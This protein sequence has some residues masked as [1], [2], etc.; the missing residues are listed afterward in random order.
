MICR[1]RVSIAELRIVDEFVRLELGTE[2]Y[3]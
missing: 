2:G 1:A 3:L